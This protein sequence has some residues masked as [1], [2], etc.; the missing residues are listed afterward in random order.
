M[1]SKK[2]SIQLISKYFHKQCQ[3]WFNDKTGT[4]F[5]YSHPPLKIWFLAFSSN[6]KKLIVALTLDIEPDYAC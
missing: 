4:V 1:P 5:H 6:S 2:W 3:R